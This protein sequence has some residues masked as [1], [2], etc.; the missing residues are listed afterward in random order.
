MS[1]TIHKVQKGDTLYNI[2]KRAGCTVQ[3]IKEWNN[4]TSDALSIGQELSVK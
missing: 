1:G 2:A 4:L 3:Q